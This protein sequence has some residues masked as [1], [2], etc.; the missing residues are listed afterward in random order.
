MIYSIRYE[1]LHLP[2][3]SNGLGICT[4]HEF[5]TEYQDYE[6]VLNIPSAILANEDFNEPN[7]YM[8]RCLILLEKPI[9][10]ISQMIW[11][12]N[13]DAMIL[14]KFKNTLAKN[15]INSRS[16]NTFVADYLENNILTKSAIITLHKEGIVI[17][18]QQKELARAMWISFEP[19]AYSLKNKG[20]VEGLIEY[21]RCLTLVKA[22]EDNNCIFFKAASA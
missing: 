14:S 15:I 18:N 3:Y 8:H 19:Y 12:C 22:A 7:E 16:D 10:D 2:C 6:I 17:S 9:L 21:Q 4:V 11:V 5:K 13:K 1:H 20:P